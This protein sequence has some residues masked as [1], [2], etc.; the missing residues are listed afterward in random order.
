M[1]GRNFYSCLWIYLIE[2]TIIA[3]VLK[4]VVFDLPTKFMIKTPNVEVY[5]TRFVCSLLLHME[6]IEDVK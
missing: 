4:T 6:L 5:F 3:L 1:I 2:M